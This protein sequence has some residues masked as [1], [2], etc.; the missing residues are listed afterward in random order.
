M[1]LARPAPAM[2]Q[3]SAG[4]AASTQGLG[5]PT[6]RGSRPKIVSELRPLP[7]PSAF[8]L[9]SGRLAIL[10]RQGIH[11]GSADQLSKQRLPPQKERAIHGTTVDLSD[12]NSGWASRG[13]L[14]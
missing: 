12:I 2:D 9:Y 3:G 13:R 5:P 11:L 8:V 14:T 4:W 1:R 6:R 10:H 7:S